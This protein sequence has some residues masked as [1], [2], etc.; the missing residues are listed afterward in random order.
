[1]LFISQSL[2]TAIVSTENINFWTSRHQKNTNMLEFIMNKFSDVVISLALIYGILNICSN[3][4]I[5]VPTNFFSKH[6]KN[7]TNFFLFRI[8]NFRCVHGAWMKSI[9]LPTMYA[10]NIYIGVLLMQYVCS[11]WWCRK[12]TNQKKWDSI[13]YC[14]RKTNTNSMHFLRSITNLL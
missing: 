13:I 7:C 5:Q 1:M 6:N 2:Y 14:E 9:V 12:C 3:Y 11:K 8:L 4:K 10:I